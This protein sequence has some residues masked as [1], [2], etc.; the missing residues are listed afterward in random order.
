M[1]GGAL[2]ERDGSRFVPTPLARGPWDPAAQHGGPPAALAARCCER[3]PGGEGMQ[4]ARI[5]VELLRP[6]PLQ[7]LTVVTRL[8]R[9]GK[10]VQLVETS[11][12][13]GDVEVLRATALRMRRLDLPLPP[14]PERPVPPPG[15]PA[16]AAALPPWSSAGWRP[17][18]H[19]DA[20]EHR[21]VAGS[22][23]RPGPATD[24]IRLR[25][26]LVAD[27]PTSPLCRAV[28][29]ADFGNGVSWV[30]PRSDGWIFINPDLTVALHREPVGEWVCLEAT[31]VPE[32]HGIGLAESRLWDERGPI[33]RAVQTLLLDR[34]PLP[35][36]P[37]RDSALAREKQAVGDG[38]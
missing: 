2:F 18:F 9:A 25:V 15:P 6:V 31:T 16:G 5:T 17:A 10:K 11:M 19:A 27:E 24:W 13:A 22:F 36:E 32:P 23:D 8:A 37:H 38:E 28:A 29:A 4:V 7:P 1:T 14:Q 3:E 34:V 26:P 12:R 20:V 35:P 30:L 21:F 33:G